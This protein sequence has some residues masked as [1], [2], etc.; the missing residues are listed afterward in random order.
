MTITKHARRRL[1]ALHLT[2]AQ[3]ILL[4]RLRDGKRHTTSGRSRRPLR[5]LVELGL[6][7]VPA[8]T[9]G[10]GTITPLGLDWLAARGWLDR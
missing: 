8:G 5:T 6:A 4:Y 3:E 10:P 1:R 2:T 9:E 7:T